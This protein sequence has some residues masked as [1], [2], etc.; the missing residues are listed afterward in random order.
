MSISMALAHEKHASKSAP[1]NLSQEKLSRINRDYITNI[2]PIFKEKCFDCH[3]NQT[4][5]PWYYKI[6]GVKQL[7]DRDIKESKEHIDMSGDFPFKSHESP[8]EDLKAIAE[9][10][11]ENEMPPWRYILLHTDAKIS[12]EEKKKIFDWVTSSLEAL[13]N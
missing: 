11:Q 8:A 9:E 4:R 12:V 3:S 13:E 10:I 5:F 7:I 6:P 1:A 2:K